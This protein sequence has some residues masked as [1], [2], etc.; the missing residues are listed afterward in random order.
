MKKHIYILSFLTSTLFA[1]G[2]QIPSNSINSYALAT[3]YVANANGADSAYF[4]PANMVYNKDINEIE[5]SL[6]YISLPSM[7]YSPTGGNGSI[8]TKDHDTVIPSLHYV[9]PRLTD[10][11]LRLGFSI[12]VPYGLTREWSDQ[13]AKATAKKFSLKTIE[14]NPSIA[15]PITKDLSIAFGIRYMK[16]EGE[17]EL[18]AL[19][20]YSVNMS[21]DD[22]AFAYNI[23]LS[24]KATDKLQLALTYRSAITLSTKGN[25]V[26]ASPW[27]TGTIGA[28]LDVEI[29]DNLIIG[30]A[31]DFSKQ[32]TVEVNYDKTFWSKVTQTDFNYANA[33]LEASPLGTSSPKLWDDTVAYRIGITHKL[34][35]LLTLMGG[36][37][38]STNAASEAYVSYSSPEA[39]SMTYS[40]GGRYSLNNNLDIGLSFLYADYKDRTSAQTPTTGVRGALSEKTAFAITTGIAYKF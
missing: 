2:Y 19:P 33:I 6:S 38:Y 3:A 18:D 1:A 23:A 13:P 30:A 34:D 22:D 24:Y 17:V 25:A 32:T 8:K 27:F 16:G 4:N 35:N 20:T 15:L 11:G 37:A 12:S 40:F 36:I 7:K 21:G 28:A 14:F 9:S 39:D 31:Y 10:N 29:P 26:V 5:A